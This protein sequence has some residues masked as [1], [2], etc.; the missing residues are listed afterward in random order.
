VS[1]M[2]R[3]GVEEYE[4][5]ERQLHEETEIPPVK[6]TSSAAVLNVRR[7]LHSSLTERDAWS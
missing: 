5:N 7:S 3:C 6:V 1:F 2:L 4:I